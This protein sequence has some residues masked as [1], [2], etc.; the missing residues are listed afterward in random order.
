[1]EN[2]DRF[3]V[4]F[5]KNVCITNLVRK[6]F[7]NNKINQMM[8][9]MVIYAHNMAVRPPT[10]NDERVCDACMHACAF[11]HTISVLTHRISRIENFGHC[12]WHGWNANAKYEA[13]KFRVST[14][15]VWCEI[16]VRARRCN[17]TFMLIVVEHCI[18]MY[19]CSRFCLSLFGQRTCISTIIYPFARFLECSLYTPNSME[20]QRIYRVFWCE[21]SVLGAC[22][23]CLFGLLLCCVL[24]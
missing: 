23:G 20:W 1:M 9:M 18:G 4:E 17:W 6:W 12:I 2:M 8:M 21:S 7:S 14:Y 10:C 11:L 22:A 15:F 3:R 5:S 16:A 19:A 24:H 13:R